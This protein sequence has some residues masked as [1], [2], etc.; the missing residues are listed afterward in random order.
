M[1]LKEN[2]SSHTNTGQWDYFF[3]VMLRVWLDN[4][5]EEEEE[6]RRSESDLYK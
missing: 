6:E 2:H 3:S 1:T 5:I 4:R